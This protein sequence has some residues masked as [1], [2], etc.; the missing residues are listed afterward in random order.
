[1]C[2]CRSGGC[3]PP[4]PSDPSSSSVSLSLSTL[5]YLCPS[6]CNLFSWGKLN[7]F[8]PQGCKAWQ[9][10]ASLSIDRIYWLVWWLRAAR[11]FPPIIPPSPRVTWQPGGGAIG[12]SVGIRRNNGYADFQWTFS[13]QQTSVRMNTRARTRTR[14]R[15][16][17]L[18]FRFKFN[19][20]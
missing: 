20:I 13:V 14:T 16:H 3:R 2:S 11:T 7:M 17:T 8:F 10:V 9:L 19:T 5:L 1:M 12:E 4:P 15:T 6:L 18:P